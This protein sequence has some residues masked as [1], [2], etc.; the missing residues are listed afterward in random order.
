MTPK[1][2]VFDVISWFG[3]HVSIYKALRGTC[4]VTDLVNT[5]SVD[6]EG[7]YGSIIIIIIIMMMMMMMMIIT[8]I[9]SSYKH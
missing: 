6:V 4:C 7:S 2:H 1:V 5:E 8:A 3:G 9:H